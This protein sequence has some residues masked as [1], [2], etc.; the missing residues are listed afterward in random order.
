M[1]A[2]NCLFATMT[3]AA[4]LASASAGWATVGGARALGGALVA[5]AFALGRGRS[6]RTSRPVLSWARSIFGTLSMLTTFYALSSRELAV[7]DA[8]TLFATAPLFIALLSPVVLR[9]RTDPALWGVLV[10]AFVGVVLVAGPHFVQG[11][12]KLLSLGSVPAISAFLAAVFSATA[13]MFLRMM[14]AGHG[15]GPPDS[16]EA[17]AFHFATLG[18]VVHAAIASLDFHSPTLRDSGFLALAGVSGGLAQLAMTRAYALAPAAKL[19]A[20]GYAGTVL[21]FAGAVVFLGERPGWL[22]L[23]GAT[24]VVGAGVVLALISARGHAAGAA[25]LGTS[26]STAADAERT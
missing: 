1:M 7:G 9:E 21:G 8:V 15:G 18:F 24:L 17:I 14:R 25:P 12:G 23:V 13:M 20:V 4:R 10:F 11:G 5:A 22:Q 19:G 16:P 2:A 3:I 6:L 26:T